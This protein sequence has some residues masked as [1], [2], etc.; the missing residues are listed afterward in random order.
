MG[1]FTKPTH[2]CPDGHDVKGELLG[3]S[4]AKVQRH[5]GCDQEGVVEKENQKMRRVGGRLAEPSVQP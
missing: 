1:S 2:F 5:E 3:G 4:L